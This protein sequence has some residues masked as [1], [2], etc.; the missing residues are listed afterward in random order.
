MFFFSF[1]SK[2][3]SVYFRV[4]FLK[5]CRRKFWFLLWLT[6][7]SVQHVSFADSP[8]SLEASRFFVKLL[9]LWVS[10][11]VGCVWRRPSNSYH[12][13]TNATFVKQPAVL[14]VIRLLL[15]IGQ[16]FSLE[17]LA[18]CLFWEHGCWPGFPWPGWRS[19]WRQKAMLISLGR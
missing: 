14:A 13:V 12:C 19:L 15:K 2:Q 10:V 16:C 17:M 1:F 3:C 8:L 6:R 9:R 4:L 11:L 18:G 7:K 5:V